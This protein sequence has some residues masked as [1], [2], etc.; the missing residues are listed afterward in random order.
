MPNAIAKMHFCGICRR[1]DN[2]K[3]MYTAGHGAKAKAFMAK[4]IDKFT[5]LLERRRYPPF[6]CVFCDSNIENLEHLASKAHGAACRKFCKDHRCTYDARLCGIPVSL[7]ETT[8]IDVPDEEPVLVNPRRDELQTAFLNSVTQSLE[9]R[10]NPTSKPKP[11]TKNVVSKQGI[12][13]NPSG[14]D[15]DS[16][17]KV[18]GGGIVK[19]A[20]KDLSPWPIDLLVQEMLELHLNPHKNTQKDEILLKATEMAFGN[21]LSSITRKWKNQHVHNIH[22][23]AI[24]P[25]M[26]TSTKEYYACNARSKTPWLPKF[27]GVW[28]SGSQRM[29]EVLASKS[30]ASMPPIPAASS[31]APATIPPQKSLAMQ[32]QELRAKMLLKKQKK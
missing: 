14:F 13:Q 6:W 26:V 10:K 7:P 15:A 18:W 27:N 23:N 22:S 21:G 5:S 16:G 3:H 12:V 8:T 17:K 9:Q 25:W 28:N 11:L 19:I 31:M 20:K 29:Q 32:K 24:P 4:Q 30:P 1:N 2:K